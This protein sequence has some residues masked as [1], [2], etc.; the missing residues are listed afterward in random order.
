MFCLCPRGYGANSFRIG[1]SIQYGAIP[2]YISDE[3]ILPFNINFEDFGVLI[4]AEDAAKTHEILHSIPYETIYEKQKRLPEIYQRYYTY[5]G[6]M[7]EIIK[8]LESEN[9]PTS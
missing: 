6:C 7:N 8:C 1:E 2:V 4:K 3:F 5:N 9:A